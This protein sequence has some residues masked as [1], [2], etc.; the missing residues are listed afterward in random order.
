M[1]LNYKHSSVLSKGIMTIIVAFIIIA[2]V[3]QKLTSFL[4]LPHKY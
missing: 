2:K 1:L 4:L 3:T